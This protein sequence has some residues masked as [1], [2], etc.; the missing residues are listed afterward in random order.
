M[1][2][3][4]GSNLGDRARY[5][6]DARAAIDRIPGTHVLAASAIEETAPFGPVP[7]GPYLNQMLAV[8]TTLTPG[9]LLAALLDIERNAGRTRTRRWGPRTLDLD[10]VAYVDGRA[11]NDTALTVPHPGLADRDFWQREVAELRAMLARV[12]EP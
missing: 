2:V 5:L 1:F 6:A 8:D 12:G 7:Q 3:A 4:L 11:V 10:V 9:A